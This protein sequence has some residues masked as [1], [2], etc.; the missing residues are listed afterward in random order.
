[1]WLVSC[2]TTP[3][4]VEQVN[5]RFERILDLLARSGPAIGMPHVR[6]IH[7]YDNLWEMRVRHRTGAYRLFFGV[8]GRRIAAAY[9]ASKTS[10][11]FPD[12]VYRR[13]EAAVQALLGEE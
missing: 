9:G 5:V 3:D 13:A 6:K 2:H 11:D 8:R 1:M 12:S 10:D 4:A 7:N